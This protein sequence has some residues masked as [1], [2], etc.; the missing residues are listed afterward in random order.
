[1]ERNNQKRGEKERNGYVLV[2]GYALDNSVRTK[3][4]QNVEA[5]DSEIEKFRET[6][7]YFISVFHTNEYWE[8]I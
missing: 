5:V 3:F 1:M 8:F 7:A 2:Y 6:G 4:I